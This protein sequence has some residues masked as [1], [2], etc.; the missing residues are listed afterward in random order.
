MEAARAQPDLLKEG[1]GPVEAAAAEG[2]EEL[3]R[4]VGREAE[5]DDEATNQFNVYDGAGRPIDATSPTLP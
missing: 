3:L 1:G 4:A 2:A 5:P